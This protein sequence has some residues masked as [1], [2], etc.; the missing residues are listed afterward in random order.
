MVFEIENY[1]SLKK[2]LNSLCEFLTLEKVDPDVVFDSRLAACELLGNV[3]QHSEG[4]ATLHGEVD[5]DFIQLK[6]FSDTPFLPTEVNLPSLFS[7]H[8]R[9]LFLVQ[10]LSEGIEPIQG[11]ILLKIKMR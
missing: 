3:L 10:S 8:G 5:G 4:S 1:T 9:G 7:E 11:G 2:A 6:I